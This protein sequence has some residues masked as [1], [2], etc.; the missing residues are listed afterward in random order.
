MR[1]RFF[2]SAAFL[3][4][5]GCD[6]ASEPVGEGKASAGG[7]DSD[8]TT[9]TTSGGSMSSTTSG[10]PPGDSTDATS[11]EPDETGSS[12]G[13]LCDEEV[14][15]AACPAGMTHR[16]CVDGEYLCTCVPVDTACELEPMVCE[17]VEGGKVLPEDV[18]DCGTATVSDD[19]SVYE[20]VRD[21]VLDASQTSAAYKAF[22]QLQGIDSEVWSAY[23]AAVG[24]VYQELLWT[25]DDHFGNQTIWART[26]TPTASSDATCVPGPEEGLCIVCENEATL[27]VVCS[28]E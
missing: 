5:V 20:A 6:P 11:D 28:T 10:Q 21:C 2:H 22:V 8:T 4:A 12:G 3:L 15:C 16:G 27:D 25:Y 1:L 7:S 17:V 9:S 26:C 18:V 23:G 14:D 19:V 24:V 13:P